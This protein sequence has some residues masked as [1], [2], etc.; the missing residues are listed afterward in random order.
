MYHYHNNRAA[1]FL[2]NLE[3]ER[4]FFL[5]LSSHMARKQENLLYERK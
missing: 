4:C 5:K 1:L 3:K 2:I